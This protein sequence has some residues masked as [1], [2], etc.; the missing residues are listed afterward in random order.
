MFLFRI[1]G[2]LLIAFIGF[3]F[4]WKTEK[5]LQNFGTITWAEIKFGPGGSRTFYKLLGIII[6]LVGF[7]LA[8]NLLG[9]LLLGTV[10]RLF[11]PPP[12]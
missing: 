11:V 10:G 9:N 8:T 5:Y 12:R 4:V 7:M 2:G 1:I 6:I 3:T